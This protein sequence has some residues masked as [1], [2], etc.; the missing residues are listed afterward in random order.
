MG[1]NIKFLLWLI[2]TI[3]VWIYGIIVGNYHYIPYKEIKFLKD[4]VNYYNYP[5]DTV[6]PDYSP[7]D[8]NSY[9]QIKPSSLISVNERNIDSIRKEVIKI[10]FGTSILPHDLPYSISNKIDRR[11]D[12]LK[13]LKKIEQFKIKMDYGLISTGYIFKPING[14]NQLIIYHQGHD[15]DFLFNKST[16]DFF[17]NHGYTVYAFCMPLFGLNNTV[18]INHKKLGKF[19]LL[20]HED[21]QYLENPLSY[22][23]KPVIV[24][25]NYATQHKQFNT[26]K[27]AGISGGGWTTTI[28]PAID[29]RIK[30]SYPIAGTYPMYIRFS[31]PEKNKG[32]Y[33]QS[34]GPLY[35]KI[36]YL[37][38]YVL[39]SSTNNRKQL[40]I[41]NKY[42]PCCYSGD[43]HLN[44]QKD[45]QNIVRKLDGHFDLFIDSSHNGGHIISDMTAQRIIQ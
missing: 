1:K 13:N 43:L 3:I 35:S 10:I 41:L 6:S 23:V 39:G 5:K 15:G 8:K 2:L 30:E 32:D 29:V 4:Y 19:K 18:T 12:D 9:L 11:Y 31:L 42:D 28:C 21:F 24:M 40:Q 38:L 7:L 33:E 37:D 14:N 22:F 36:N 27:M 25:L 16:I 20:T 44:Y 26:I 17:V 34:Y 45:V